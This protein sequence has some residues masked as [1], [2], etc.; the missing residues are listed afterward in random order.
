M[1]VA[2]SGRGPSGLW[3]L[4]PSLVAMEAEADR[5]AP[6]RSIASDGSIGDAAHAARRS[7]HNPDEE[8][9]LDYV[10]ALDLTHDPRNG[11]DAHAYARL[12]ARNVV[13]GV[14][15]RIDYI[16]SNGQIFSR[17]DGRWAWRPYSGSSP[18]TQHAHFSVADTGR[19]DTSTWFTSRPL[20]PTPPPVPTMEDDD[21]YLRDRETGNIY[22]VS[23]T[24][25]QHLSPAQWRDRERE[26][27]K[28][29]NLHPLEVLARLKSRVK[30]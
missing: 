24:H 3:V 15:R 7:D 25:F 6:K 20:F 22:A 17:R 10:D 23:A 5:I 16:I 1:S 9:A 8:G 29:I 18:H 21:V 13:N 11:F 28:F 19:A 2:K 4:A 30:V 27:A 14:E 26:G 12:V